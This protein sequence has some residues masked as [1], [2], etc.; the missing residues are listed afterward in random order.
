MK[1]PRKEILTHHM[2]NTRGIKH[3]FAT[4]PQVIPTIPLQFFENITIIV[5]KQIKYNTREPPFTLPTPCNISITHSN[6]FCLGVR[7]ARQ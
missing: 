6:F 3:A 5:A 7:Y 1:I 2:K 4:R